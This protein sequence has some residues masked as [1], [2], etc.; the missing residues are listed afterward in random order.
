[1]KLC[2]LLRRIETEKQ[3]QGQRNALSTAEREF[4]NAER[5]YALERTL[6][7]GAKNRT[8]FQAFEQIARALDLY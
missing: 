3:R 7:Q 2:D 1:M 5:L 6:Q 4:L 8:A